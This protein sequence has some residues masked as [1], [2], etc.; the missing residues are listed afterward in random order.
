MRSGFQPV[1]ISCNEPDYHVRFAPPVD[2]RALSDNASDASNVLRGP[3][4]CRKVNVA[5]LAFCEVGRI[6]YSAAYPALQL[7]QFDLGAFVLPSK[8]VTA[9][10][11]CHRL[12][13]RRRC[14]R[15]Q[16]S[17]ALQSPARCLRRRSG[18][19][20][21]SLRVGGGPLAKAANGLVGG[22]GHADTMDEALG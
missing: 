4:L 21:D 17:V 5:E 19:P 8:A 15:V 2:A 20:E 9:A 3:I 13:A 16:R 18:A 14:L 11:R 12:A 1:A 10:P 22:G 6:V 7:C